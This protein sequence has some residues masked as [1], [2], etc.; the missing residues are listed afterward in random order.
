MDAV[1]RLRPPPAVDAP[2]SPEINYEEY[3]D[4]G[5]DG[6]DDDYED[7]EGDDAMEGEVEGEE[8]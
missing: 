6:D 5:D 3:A 2:S 1:I 7:D 4:D 8:A